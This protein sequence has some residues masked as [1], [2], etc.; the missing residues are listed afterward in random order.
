M[1]DVIKIRIAISYSMGAGRHFPTKTRSHDQLITFR[2]PLTYIPYD[3][4]NNRALFFYICV[5]I[6]SS[7]DRSFT[8]HRR[9]NSTNLHKLHCHRHFASVV[10]NQRMTVHNSTVK[11]TQRVSSRNLNCSKFESLASRYWTLIQHD[12]AEYTLNADFS[13]ISL[14]IILK[15]GSFVFRHCFRSAVFTRFLSP[16]DQWKRRCCLNLALFLT[17]VKLYCD[18]MSS[19]R[20]TLCMTNCFVSKR[21][22]NFVKF[23]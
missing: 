4:D 7:S 8:C 9:N 16:I 3:V 23:R 13:D 15:I 11:T 10:K 14:H 17:R 22:D 21:P 6:R 1:W 2:P 18:V 20:L 12:K 5:N 19:S